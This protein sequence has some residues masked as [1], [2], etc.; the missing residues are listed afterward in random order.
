MLIPKQILLF[1]FNLFIASLV[2]GQTNEGGAVDLV[3]AETILKDL[4]NGVLLV[5]IPTGYKKISEINK[6]LAKGKDNSRLIAAR[7]KEMAHITKAQQGLMHGFKQFYTFSSFI[8]VYDTNY[9]KV[10]KNPAITG[11][12]I[13]TSFKEVKD[14]SLS[15]KTFATFREDQFFY[16]AG[17]AH[18]GFT[19]SDNRG[20]VP[21]RP[22]GIGIPYK[23]RQHSVMPREG[24]L[25]RAAQ[26][27]QGTYPEE[28][29][30][31]YTSRFLDKNAYHAVVKMLQ[32]K[33]ELYGRYLDYKKG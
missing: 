27:L 23:F 5:K 19:L 2:Y 30:K 8:G 3:C 33:L 18:K 31:N 24:A 17:K 6:T 28:F 22:F 11:V 26:T 29:Y 12:F 14:F 20:L 16:D 1:I 25:P 7:D 15:G 4:K 21:N 32:I 10:L 9:A 13:D